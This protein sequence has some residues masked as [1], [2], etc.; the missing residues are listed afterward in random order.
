MIK[1]QRAYRNWLDRNAL[2]DGVNAD[3]S[4][5]L[6]LFYANNTIYGNQIN[7]P[8][9]TQRP[10]NIKVTLLNGDHFGRDLFRPAFALAVE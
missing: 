9:W 1:A 3:P 7:L 4:A 6:T 5:D 2:P 8:S 10:G